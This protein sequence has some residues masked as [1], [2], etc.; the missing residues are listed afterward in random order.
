M[1]GEQKGLS[2]N[3]GLPAS[4]ITT[5]NELFA[6]LLK[7]YNAIRNLA[8]AL[9]NYTG[10][11]SEPS[12]VWS[13]LGATRLLAGSNAK[14]YLVCSVAITYGQ[15]VGITGAGQAALADD[16]VLRCIGF[17][18]APNGGGIGDTIEVQLFGLYPPFPP[19][20]LTPGAR[21]SQSTTAGAIG[22]FGS[23]VQTV[24]FAISD[25]LLYFNPEL[26]S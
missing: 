16:G 24:G 14:I 6:E 20:S 18:S 25:T 21:Y 3:L 12:S 19:A 13:Q 10:I 5:N 8:A 11:I 7:V 22:G 9:D 1:A 26:N 23:G 2:V 15:T 17:C 4:P